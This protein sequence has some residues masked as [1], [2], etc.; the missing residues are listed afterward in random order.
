VIRALSFALVALGLL[1]GPTQV[2][3][4]SAPA[5]VRPRYR[6][7]PVA[8]PALVAASLGF[9]VLSEAVIH[10]GELAV[11]TPGPTSRILGIDRWV[12]ERDGPLAGSDLTSTLAVGALMAWGVADSALTGTVRDGDGWSELAIYV[13]VLL[14]NWAVGNLAKLAVRRPRPRA[15]LQVRETGSVD[16]DTDTSLSFY[17]LHSA[18]AAGMTA[19]ASYLAFRRDPGSALAWTTLGVGTALTLFTGLQRMLAMAHFPT[20]VLAGILVGGGIGLLV[21]HAHSADSAVSVLPATDGSSWLGG[22]VGGQF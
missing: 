10:S 20:D 1:S 2:R 13:E 5:D 15:Y 14:V 9:A 22:L 11:V 6:I 7:D 16:G 18:F 12:A 4:Q 17:S 19:A 8:D 21:A 3:A